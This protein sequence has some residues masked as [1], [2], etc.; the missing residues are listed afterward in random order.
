MKKEGK[1]KQAIRSIKLWVGNWYDYEYALMPVFI[2]KDAST[3]E[4]T[5]FGWRIYREYDHT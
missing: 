3:F 1:I 4:V 5:I 2:F